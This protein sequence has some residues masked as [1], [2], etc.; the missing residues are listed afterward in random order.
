MWP[1][2]FSDNA[3]Q[4]TSRRSTTVLCLLALS[5]ILGVVCAAQSRRRPAS[6]SQTQPA[7]GAA[8]RYSAF[9]H[10]SA[11]HQSL[12]CNA[13]HKVP[14]IWTARREF[15]D[16]ADFPDHEACV[17]CHRQQFFTRQAIV[18]TGPTICTVCHIRAAPQEEGRFAFG[19]PNNAQ[20]KQKAKVEQQFRIEFP[21][22]KHQNVIASNLLPYRRIRLVQVS[23]A[24]Q[25]QQRTN[26]HNCTLCH[27]TN[28]DAITAPPTGWVDAFVPPAGTFKSMPRAHDSC[29]DCHWQSQKPTSDDCAGCH[30]R[31]DVPFVP[32][33][34]PARKSAKFNHEAGGT[35]KVHQVECTSCHINITRARTLRGLTPDVPIASCAGCN[36]DRKKTTYGKTLKSVEDEFVQYRKTGRCTYCHTSEVGGKKPPP[37]HEIAVQ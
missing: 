24:P 14:T 21:H 33:A 23:F 2:N 34:W 37:S 6:P 36:R 25:E 32:V 1:G 17:R 26:Y 4:M 5:A 30:K 15:P 7:R 35:E 31:A 28:R 9:L 11:K 20:Q 12:A 19:L 8:A 16:V 3:D 13:C 10:S 22:D 29:F 27:L 18:G